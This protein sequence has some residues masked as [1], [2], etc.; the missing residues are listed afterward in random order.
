M[1]RLLIST[2]KSVKVIGLM[3]LMVALAAMMAGPRAASAATPPP[4]GGAAY[5]K[6]N[7]YVT[8]ASANADFRVAGA[9]VRLDSD[10]G[11]TLAKGLTNANGNFASYVPQGTYKIKVIADGYQEFSRV[12][13]IA[14]GRGTTVH[15]NL[16]PQAAVSAPAP[17]A[18][19]DPLIG[20]APAPAP[21][22]P[23][24][25]IMA[26]GKLMVSLDNVTFWG[27]HVQAKV[28]I[29]SGSMTVPVAEG[30]TDANGNYGVELPAGAYTI[31]VSA[32]GFQ[33]AKAEA[34]VAAEQATIL[35]IRLEI[36]NSDNLMAAM[37]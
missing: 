36:A 11:Q 14:G 27:A 4:A 7:V 2:A 34:K 37:E 6:I 13:K 5:G 9:I 1:N 3:G 12:V 21:A 31:I 24:V 10:G 18:G 23:P 26:K 32:D 17:I 25:P 15:A 8:T 29:Y 33:D 20:P 35:K 16:V 30:K 22:P 28:A 19:I